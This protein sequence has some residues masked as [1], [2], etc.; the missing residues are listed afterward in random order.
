[1]GFFDR[2]TGKTAAD[3]SREAAQTQVEYGE[4]ASSLLDPFKKIGEQGLN[5]SGFLTDPNQQYEYLQGNPIFQA[6]LDNANNVTSRIAAARSR[7]SAGDTALDLSK[8]FLTS[9]YPL[10]QDQ[11]QSIG[12]LLNFGQATAINQGNLLTGQGAALAGGIVG[13]ENARAQG[14][15]NLFDLSGSI[16]GSDTGQGLINKGLSFIGLG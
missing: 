16:L 5:L 13:G 9:A 15:Q 4:K 2:L 8:N 11:K 10:I 7:L 3:A 6:S 1:M 14:Y 12:D